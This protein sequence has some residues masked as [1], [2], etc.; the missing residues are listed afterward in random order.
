MTKNQ[1]THRLR[2]YKTGNSS[3]NF[4]PAK[5][6][7]NHILQKKTIY[8]SKELLKFKKPKHVSNE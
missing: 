8:L 2:I 7:I 5:K 6:D 3:F 4:N 1:T